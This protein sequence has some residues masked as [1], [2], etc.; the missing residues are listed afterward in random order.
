LL[1]IYQEKA[2][3]TYAPNLS[4]PGAVPLHGSDFHESKKLLL[5]LGGLVPVTAE[6]FPKDSINLDC[7]LERTR[8]GVAI[9]NF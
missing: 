9:G 7:P 2:A 5:R 3:L 1:D 4:T 8:S 6:F